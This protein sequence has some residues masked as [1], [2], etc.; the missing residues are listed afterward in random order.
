MT[1]RLGWPVALA[2]LALALYARNADDYF[3]G[4]DFD[5]IHSFY[6]KP[7]AYFPAL[8]WSNESGDVWLE[9]GLDPALGRGYLRPLKIW[10]LALDAAIKGIADEAVPPDLAKSRVRAA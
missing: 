7:F 5:L 3:I 8:L 10:V 6:G 2:L 1:R 9:W 4:D